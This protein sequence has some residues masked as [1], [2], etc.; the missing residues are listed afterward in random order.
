MERRSITIYETDD[1][2]EDFLL[3]AL[4]ESLGN[5]K[6]LYYPDDINTLKGCKD[7]LLVI[8]QLT[9]IDEK[10]FWELYEFC[11][12]NEIFILTYNYHRFKMKNPKFMERCKPLI[13]KVHEIG[14]TT[15][16]GAK[17][18]KKV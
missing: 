6:I 5:I 11:Q 16:Y 17:R 2:V 18:M 7:C 14:L 13:S 3:D 9:N 1:S 15:V 4:A 8:P 12:R 10:H